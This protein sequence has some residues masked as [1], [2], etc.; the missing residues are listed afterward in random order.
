MDAEAAQQIFNAG[1][2][3]EKEGKLQ[4]ALACYQ[5]AINLNSDCYVY[6]YKLG[7]IL[8][9][10]NKL[11]EAA[12]AL[13]Q[14]IALNSNDSWSYHALGEILAKQQE[15]KAA[16]EYYQ[17]AIQLNPNFSWSHYN[18][19]RI[20]HQEN[21]LEVAQSYYQQAIKIDSN[22]F[23]SHYFLAVI[24]TEFKDIATAIYHYQEAIKLN[25]QFY[26]AYYQLANHLQNQGELEEAVT[27]Y[28][29]AIELNQ[30]DFNA[31]YYLG[32]TLF[33]LQRFTEAIKYYEAAIKL[34]PDNIQ[35][36]FYLAQ[37]LITQGQTVIENYRHVIANQLPLV[38]INWELGFAQAWQQQGEFSKAIECCQRAI[39]ID[40]SV[41]M[42]Y[43]FLQ[44]IPIN[45]ED[46][47]QVI[48]FYQKISNSNST[49]PLLWGNLGDLLSIQG[50]ITT[51][52]DCYRTSCYENT[53]KANPELAKLD[54]QHHKQKAPDF[55]IVGATKCGTTS[56]FVYLNQHPQVL[57]P[58]KKEINFF[59]RN[60]EMGVPWYLAHF[61][62]IADADE[63]ITGEASPIYL[64]DEQVIQRVKQLFPET[65]LIV[66][67]RNPLD[68][69][70]SEYYHAV[71]HGL[72]NRS[73]IEIIE[74]E[75]EL[76]AT[77][78]RSKVMQNFGYLLNSIYVEKVA[79][80]MT[81][82]P[83]ENI[84]IIESESFFKEAKVIMAK[85]WDFLDLPHIAYEQDIHHN[86]G[87]YPPVTP[88]IKQKLQE[89]FIPYNQELEQYLDRKFNW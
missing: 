17:Q 1:E 21:Q 46:L 45:S 64:Y 60:F 39:E 81:N 83:T 75:K 86:I 6:Y 74:F 77:Q 15:F 42:P 24:L 37:A 59:N 23:W 52:I 82:F 80:W 89:F 67:L 79:K 10:Q 85:T 49:S 70:I 8:R 20:L 55:I 25:S 16:K 35:P 22:F 4:Q 48:T 47:N 41:K 28:Q 29:Q 88:E 12:Q 65:K 54:W 7:N 31:Y 32:Q 66:M 18:L 68:R 34:Q 57:S 51:A 3:L 62:A 53:I 30:T 27:Y 78:P 76:L 13:Q 9:Q 73:F 72:E 58:H 50:Q 43:L 56:L 11:A 2:Y 40:P 44:Y 84:L 36:Y 61:P 63:F 19:A 38:Q 5:Q 33:Q 26:P 14:A 87:S 71:N 69:T